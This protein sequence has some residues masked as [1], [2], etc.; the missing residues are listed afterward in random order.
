MELVH[1][2]GGGQYPLAPAVRLASCCGNFNVLNRQA[3]DQPG[4]DQCRT[5]KCAPS[6]Q[7]PDREYCAITDMGKRSL[8]DVS[9][10]WNGRKSG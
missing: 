7:L 2:G 10:H 8:V 4:V 1:S 6:W 3:H 9:P 5:P